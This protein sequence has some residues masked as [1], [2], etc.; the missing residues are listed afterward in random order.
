MKNLI[1]RIKSSLWPQPKP[2]LNPG[3]IR[4]LEEAALIVADWWIDKSFNTRFN[5]DN[6]DGSS[7]GRETMFLANFLSHT[8]QAEVRDRNINDFRDYLVSSIVALDRERYKIHLSCDYDPSPLLAEAAE[9]AGIDPR[10]FP[11]KSWSNIEPDNS[12]R[13]SYGYRGE[14]ITL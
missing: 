2:Q 12:V 5:Q 13:V 10:C 7:A 11:C 8:A 1:Q 6:G 3:E 9:K 4:T 14:V